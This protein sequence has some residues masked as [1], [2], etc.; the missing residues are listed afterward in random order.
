MSR[1]SVC[2]FGNLKYNEQI[3]GTTCNKYGYAA[4]TKGSP[5]FSDLQTKE[6]CNRYEEE[7]DDLKSPEQQ[8]ITHPS[9]SE[10]EQSTVSVVIIESS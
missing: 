2:P 9:Q 1:R 10:V 4:N 8:G 3:E 7:Y 5:Q 6:E